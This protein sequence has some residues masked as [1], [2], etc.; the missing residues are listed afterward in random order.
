MALDEYS[1]EMQGNAKARALAA[2]FARKDKPLI[3]FLLS[4]QKQIGF[5][6]LLKALTILDSQRE[7]RSKEK[8]I[9]INSKIAT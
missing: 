1:I 3:E 5:S 4:N 6:D 7:K 2:A 9:A 8:K